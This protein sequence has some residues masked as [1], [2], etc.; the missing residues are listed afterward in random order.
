MISVR[1][2]QIYLL[3]CTLLFASLACNYARRN[4]SQ[5]LEGLP[6]TTASIDGAQ[7][8]SIDAQG[9]LRLVLD[10]AQLTSLISEELSSQ[11][12]PVLRDPQVALRDGQMLLTGIVQQPGLNADLEMVLDVDVTSDGKPEIS[13]VSATVGMFSLPQNMLDELSSQIKSAFESKIDQRIDN[14]FIE[15]ITIGGGEMVI[16]GHAR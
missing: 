4:T 2:F 8:V 11:D 9:R 5:L 15:S 13:L 7:D 16:E 12:D 3:L 10:E 14:L 6:Q 1:K